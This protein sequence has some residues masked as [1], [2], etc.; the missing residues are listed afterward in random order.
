MVSQMGVDDRLV[1]FVLMILDFHGSSTFCIIFFSRFGFSHSNVNRLALLISI[2]ILL[3]AVLV[4]IRIMYV[5]FV[6]FYSTDLFYQR[7]KLVYSI[8]PLLSGQNLDFTRTSII[9]FF[10]GSKFFIWLSINWVL[11]YV[12]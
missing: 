5:T 12:L 3:F 2:L 9:S 1:L 10:H 6:I 7:N 8:S 4:P 11:T